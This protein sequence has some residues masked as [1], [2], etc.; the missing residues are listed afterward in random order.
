VTPENARR[1]LAA[2]T[3][4]LLADVAGLSQAQAAGRPR[5]GVFPGRA[6]KLRR[7]G[8]AAL[9]VAGLAVAGLAGCAGPAPGTGQVAG[10]LLRQGGQE[11][12]QRPMPGTVTFAAAGQ[13]QVTAQ[14]GN[15]GSFSVQLPPGQYRVS[16][17][18][19]PPVSVTVTAHH[20]AHVTLL[21][22][23]ASV[24]PPLR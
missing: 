5:A 7:A 6:M 14:V 1:E 11:A 23:L 3:E 20:A 19:P 2:A 9:A 22:R 8:A 16:G 4:Q 21:C 24:H 17:P 10:M 15:A 13:P 18:C 12:G